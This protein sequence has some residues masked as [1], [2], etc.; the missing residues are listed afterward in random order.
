[1]GE[2]LR[3]AVPLSG[4]PTGHFMARTILEVMGREALVGTV[5]NPF[6]FFRLYSQAAARRPDGTPAFSAAALAFLGRLESR[7]RGPL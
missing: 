5:S 7:Y 2:R 6:A 3:A 4:H 1:V